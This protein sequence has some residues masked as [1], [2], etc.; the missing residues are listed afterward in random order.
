MILASAEPLF[1]AVQDAWFDLDLDKEVGRIQIEKREFR[2]HGE[3]SSWLVS[4]AFDLGS[5]RSLEAEEVLEE[6]AIALSNPDFDRQ[7]AREIDRKLRKV[8]GELDPFWVRWRFVGEKKG[9][10]PEQPAEA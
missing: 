9:W 10:L 3:V 2:R 8:L 1:D 4:E 6:A 5:A 7:H